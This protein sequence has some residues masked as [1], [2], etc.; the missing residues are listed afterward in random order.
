MISILMGSKSDYDVMK[1]AEKFLKDFGYPVEVKII[2]AHRTPE[3]LFDFGKKLNESNTLVCICA[4]G[5]AAHL[6]G[7]IA[8]LTIKPVIGVPIKSSNLSG[9]DSLLSIVQM[10]KGIPVNTVAINGSVNAAIAALEIISLLDNKVR[11]KLV[12][13][14]NKQTNEV[15]ETKL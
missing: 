13:F 4:A 15:L 11:E 8:S 9:I 3:L 5:G 12:E 6:P 10:P 7:M 14:R 2:S 1:D